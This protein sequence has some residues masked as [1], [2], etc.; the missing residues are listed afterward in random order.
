MPSKA[1]LSLRA[2]T[3]S[4]KTKYRVI[5]LP[6]EVALLP[7]HS[8]TREGWSKDVMSGIEWFAGGPEEARSDPT[9]I[10]LI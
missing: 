7:A 8:L 5:R 3:P 10:R 9:A 4:N 1:S 6:Q 2:C